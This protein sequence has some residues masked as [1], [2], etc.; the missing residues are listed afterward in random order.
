ME[1]EEGDEDSFQHALKVL[2]D[3]SKVTV[4]VKVARISEFYLQ[5]SNERN[6]RSKE[7]I[8]EEI[9]RA[10]GLHDDKGKAKRRF[11]DAKWTE[12]CD[13]LMQED[14]RFLFEFDKL[15][16]G[17]ELALGDKMYILNPYQM[18]CPICGEVKTLG[19]MNQLTSMVSHLSTQHRT[20]QQTDMCIK[21]LQAW[22]QNH[23]ITPEQINDAA[24]PPEGL[25]SPAPILSTPRVRASVLTRDI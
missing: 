13:K 16:A 9:K 6:V 23:F 12:L 3:Y 22:L 4:E 14:T 24:G 25:I 10:M 21:R 15:Q 5:A 19:N 1:I 8:S 7:I 20:D 2:P 17:V 11:L 18:I